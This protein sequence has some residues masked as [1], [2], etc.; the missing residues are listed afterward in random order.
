MSDCAIGLSE[1]DRMMAALKLGCQAD[2]EFQRECIRLGL[3]QRIAIT[4]PIAQI[5]MRQYLLA[6]EARG[7]A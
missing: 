2:I 7:H 6:E 5:A 1:R 3:E 4:A